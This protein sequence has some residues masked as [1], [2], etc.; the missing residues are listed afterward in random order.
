M[1][2]ELH[3]TC[4]KDITNL[5][6]DFADGTTVCKSSDDVDEKKPPK[7]DPKSKQKTKEVDYDDHPTE[8][9]STLDSSFLD[10]FFNTKPYNPNSVAN[11]IAPE[12]EDRK[13]IVAEEVNN[14]CF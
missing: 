13:P 4:T 6:I 14:L 5:Q 11:N 9:H 1:G 2:F 10:G 8:S 7:R 3:I 12:I